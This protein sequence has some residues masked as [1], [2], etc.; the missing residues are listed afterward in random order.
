[1]KFY[2]ASRYSRYL[3][4]QLVRDELRSLGHEVTSRWINGDHQLSNEGLSNEAQAEERLRLATEDFTDVLAAEVVVSFTEPPR[5]TNSRGG[6]HV[7]FGIGL[8]LGKVCVIVGPRENVFHCL[9]NVEVFPS[10]E[11]FFA[12]LRNR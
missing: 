2:L 8:A 5:T 6:R 11:D 9:P 3:E 12:A 7:E 4:M 10:T 1:M